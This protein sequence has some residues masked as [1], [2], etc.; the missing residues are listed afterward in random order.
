[1]AIPYCKI[2]EFQKALVDYPESGNSYF[3]VIRRPLYDEEEKIASYRFTINFV[4]KFDVVEKLAKKYKY[5]KGKYE[6]LKKLED[7]VE[8]SLIEIESGN[9]FPYLIFEAQSFIAKMYSIEELDHEIKK[10]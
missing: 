4:T 8:Y 6:K 7:E 3:L 10:K 5:Q 1:M 9:D 2:D